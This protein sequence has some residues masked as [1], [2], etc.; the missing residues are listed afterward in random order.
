MRFTLKVIKGAINRLGPSTSR[1]IAEHLRTN[2]LR[3][4]KALGHWYREGV[5]DVDRNTPRRYFVA[6]LN[7]GSRGDTGRKLAPCDMEPTDSQR[8]EHERLKAEILI[9]IK[10]REERLRS[11]CVSPPKV[12]RMSSSR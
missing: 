9:E 4:A 10:A 5:L 11:P 7:A 3:T 1:E 8:A 2:P 6:A 12:Y